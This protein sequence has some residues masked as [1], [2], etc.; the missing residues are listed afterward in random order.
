MQF[1]KFGNSIFEMDA[2]PGVL[3]GVLNGRIQTNLRT[4]PDEG[5]RL[6][7]SCIRRVTSGSG[8]NRSTREKV[9][10]QD[11]FLVPGGETASGPRG[12]SVPVSLTIPY[13]SGPE[14]DPEASSP[15]EWRLE[16]AAELSGVDFAAR[17]EIPVFRTDDSDPETEATHGTGPPV[18]GRRSATRFAPPASRVSRC[19]TAASPTGSRGHARRAPPSA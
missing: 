6:M 5:V 13:E 8:K 3:G 18:D 10:W 14:S 19:P 9:L 17:F 7:L 2:T 15:V 12:V 11:T 1:R 16:A 4:R